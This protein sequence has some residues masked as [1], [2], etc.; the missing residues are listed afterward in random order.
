MGGWLAHL[1]HRARRSLGPASL[2]EA[3]SGKARRNLAGRG[4]Q[5]II[6]GLGVSRAADLNHMKRVALGM[7]NWIMTR[8]T[9]WRR[10]SRALE[11]R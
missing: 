11:P 6:A 4:A 1:R 3:R 10:P 9:V 5:W 7:W 8:N 2:V